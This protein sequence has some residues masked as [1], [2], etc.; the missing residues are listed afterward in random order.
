MWAW[1]VYLTAIGVKAV[2]IEN[3]GGRG[4]VEVARGRVEKR[5]ELTGERLSVKREMKE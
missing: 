4:E 5:V 1:P 3:M 2:T